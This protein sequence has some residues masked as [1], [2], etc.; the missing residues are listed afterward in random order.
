MEK[1]QLSLKNIYRFLTDSDYP[2][3]SMSVIPEENKKGL[4]L[5]KFW[6][7]NLL[8]EFRSG[9]CG[10]LIWRTTGGRNRYLSEICNRKEDLHFYEEYTK[11]LSE[12]ASAE[13]IF[14][15]ALQ[16]AAF[17]SQRNYSYDNFLK[18]LEAWISIL[19]EKDDFFTKDMGIFFRRHLEERE[20]LQI[21]V[22]GKSFLCGYMLTFLM[23]HAMAGR[24]MDV[25]EMKA[26][27]QE[28]KKGLEK[29][30][31]QYGQDEEEKVGELIY[32]TNQNSEICSQALADTSFLGREEDFFELREMLERGGHYLISGIGGIG[33]TELL[34]Q[35]LK[36]VKREKNVDYI[37][38]I[39]YETSMADSF[40]RAFDYK[41]GNKTEDNFREVLSQIRSKENAKVL[42]L[43]D[44]VNQTELEDEWIKQ[45]EDLR[46]T[47]FMTTRVAE[48]QG[49]ETYSL[50]T[51]T[52]EAGR[53]IFRDNYNRQ[54]SRED[55]AELDEMLQHKMWCHPLT[56]R[57]LG[58]AANAKDWSIREL[59][60]HISKGEK[61]FSWMEGHV[62]FSLEQ[63]Y[64]RMYSIAGL[65]REQVK[66]LRMLAMLPY[67]SY[68]KE[69]CQSYLGQ[70]AGLTECLEELYRYGWLEKDTAGY[71]MHPFIAECVRNKRPRE[72][73][74]AD[75]FK[76]I[77]TQWRLEVLQETEEEDVWLLLKYKIS[78][79]KLYLAD[80]VLYVAE[81]LEGRLSKELVELCLTA[82]EVLLDIYGESGSYLKKIKKLVSKGREN[83]EAARFWY[84]IQA[85]RW[86]EAGY[87][88][89]EQAMEQQKQNR[90]I[91]ELMYLEGCTEWSQALLKK[92]K[93]DEAENYLQEVMDGNSLSIQKM[94]ACYYMSAVRYQQG[95]PTET[96]AWAKR[97]QEYAKEQNSV[98]EVFLLLALLNAQG[99]MSIGLGLLEETIAVVEK[100]EK[101]L[102][103]CDSL[104]MR[105]HVK[106]LQGR[107][108]LAKEEPKQA[109]A[110]LRE[111]VRYAGYYFGSDGRECASYYADL[112]M[113][114]NRAGERE[115]AL[116]Y[117]SKALG[118]MLQCKYKTYDIHRCYN[119][120]G[121]VYLD[122]NR[123]QEALEYFKEAYA[124]GQEFGGL[125]VAEPA[126]NISRAYEMLGRSAEGLP[127]VQAAYPVMEEFYGAEHPK[128][129]DAKRRLENG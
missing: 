75:F 60:E 88:L 102:E 112:G 118:I 36:Y 7:E 26:L 105:S 90:S 86:T 14:K 44:N 11:E 127:F 57:L 51:P 34:R 24:C 1:Q 35:L 89:L 3:Y 73:D 71:S 43:I 50:D 103:H 58:R 4:T 125:S 67:G 53:L 17:L 45:L 74:F 98:T 81:Q 123:P 5:L 32:L 128:V 28:K 23:L 94:K 30:W 52:K 116:E 31:Q 21:K 99:Q 59:K 63:V 40:L 64:K 100:M 83:T 92:A 77:E 107:V 29:L 38:V 10:K 41:G 68:S 37:G 42:L 121:V 49:F 6:Q 96:L 120:A 109:V 114:L 47:I 66:L 55:K 93:F 19:E 72:E 22:E 18:R 124:M 108:L 9:K 2:I 101:L 87:A 15:Q 25:T 106:H 85:A 113:A 27:R 80:L 82:S 111:G 104:I 61:E 95:N 33:K 126:N 56:L 76:C 122:M 8:Y 39:Q 69:F 79:Q 70:E 110:C 119:N 117:Y 54:L 84:A 115:E 20:R 13:I 78:H 97:G 16:F 65:Q 62:S 129:L 12:A 48:V 91:S 46:A